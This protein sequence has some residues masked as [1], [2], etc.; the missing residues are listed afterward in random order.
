MFA[1]AF[2]KRWLGVLAM[3]LVFAVACVFLGQWQFAR[4][5]EARAAIALLD[6]NHDR[7]AVP[8]ETVLT[9]KTTDS[10]ELKWLPVIINGQYL[11][12][13]TA[14]A[15]NRTRNGQIGFEQ[16]VPFKTEQGTVFVVDRGWIAA[17]EDYSAPATQPAVPSADLTV[18]ARLIPGEQQITGRNAPAGQLATI[19]LPGLKV[20]TGEDLYTGF[21]GR[22]VSEEPDSENG[23][24]W[25]RP[26][27][28]E[29]PHLSYAL[30]W[31]VFALMA[32]FAYF[33]ALLKEYRISSGAS[34]RTVK[35]PRSRISKLSD[36]EIEDA[37]T[38]AQ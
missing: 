3:V 13:E 5:A 20:A 33:W 24:L 38:R 9:D 35:K 4:R 21:Y 32:F 27:L 2:S 15:R 34:P 26:V 31:Y 25:E 7:S 16:I 19:N 8:L 23:E 18:V 22:L 28:D 14:Y 17:N 29:G 6:A 36:E 12:T 37:I 1:L 30:Q 11:I 10:T